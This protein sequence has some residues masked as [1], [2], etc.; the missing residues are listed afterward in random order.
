MPQE[1]I[2]FMNQ[3]ALQQGGRDFRKN[4]LIFS[5][6]QGTIVHE[7]D[8]DNNDAL[9][10]TVPTTDDVNYDEV[11]NQDPPRF[12]LQQTADVQIAGAVPVTDGDVANGESC[13]H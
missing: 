8:S 4:E 12:D 2:N 11:P 13:S 3:P 7:G 9:P 10:N 5:H 1:V 6:L